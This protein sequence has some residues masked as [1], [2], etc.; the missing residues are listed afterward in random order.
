MIRKQMKA[1]RAKP[2]HTAMLKLVDAFLH[3][4]QSEIRHCVGEASWRQLSQRSVMNFAGC[5]LA[6]V[7]GKSQVEYLDAA[8]QQKVRELC[9]A[10]F[11]QDQMELAE[12][13]RYI[14]P[15][16]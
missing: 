12:L 9:R 4:Y 11:G 10:I 1:I 15:L 13:S 7:D 14:G 5:A 16:L 6:R 8:Q 3:S 2:R